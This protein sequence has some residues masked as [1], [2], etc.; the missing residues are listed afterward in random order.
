[1]C[2][3]LSVL[4]NVLHSVEIDGSQ[5]ANVFKVPV[6]AGCQ[7]TGVS[8]PPTSSSVVSLNSGV[9]KSTLKQRTCFFSRVK[10]TFAVTS[11]EQ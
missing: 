1:M 11:T 6:P 9:K 8:T 5:T 7:V 10:Q 2:D 3:G 4:S